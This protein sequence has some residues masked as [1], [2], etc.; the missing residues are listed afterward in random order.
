[1]ATETTSVHFQLEGH[2]K[3]AVFFLFT[4]LMQM[5]HLGASL[6]LFGTSI[7]PLRVFNPCRDDQSS[8]P[9]FESMGSTTILEYKYQR[10][11]KGFQ[12][13][14]VPEGNTA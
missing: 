2:A 14:I 6:I 1:M 7:W 8:Y 13:T 3:G 4:Q 10:V 12:P 5:L 11:V 9:S